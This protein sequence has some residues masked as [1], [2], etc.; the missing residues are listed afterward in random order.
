MRAIDPLGYM[1]ICWTRLG[2][3]NSLF[4]LF[5]RKENMPM[6]QADKSRGREWVH[7]TYFACFSERFRELFYRSK[8]AIARSL[9]SC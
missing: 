7:R 9:S 4:Q 8:L 3:H 1:Y 2:W 6:V 5:S